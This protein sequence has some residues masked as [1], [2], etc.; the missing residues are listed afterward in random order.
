MSKKK[1]NQLNDNNVVVENEKVTIK[2][3]ENKESKEKKKK[4]KKKKSTNV[5]MKIM[6]IFMLLLMLA[7][8]IIGIIAYFI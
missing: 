7:S 6:G 3:K 2:A 8:A 1:E 5:G 4:K